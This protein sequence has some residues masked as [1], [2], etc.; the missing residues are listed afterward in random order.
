MTSPLA[1][2]RSRPSATPRPLRARAPRSQ[3]QALVELA[4][5]LP[6]FL[7]LFVAALDLGRLFYSQITVNDASR[8]GVLEASRNPTSFLP[9]TACTTANRDTNRIMCRA[10]E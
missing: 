8:E 2:G 7:V 9:N 1:G 6:L 4:L 5:I 10:S 3:G